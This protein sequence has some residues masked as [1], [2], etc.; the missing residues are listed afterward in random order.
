MYTTSVPPKWL[1][2]GAHLTNNLSKPVQEA[3]GGMPYNL[4][5]VVLNQLITMHMLYWSMWCMSS[6]STGHSYLAFNKKIDTLLNLK[7]HT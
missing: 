7:K 4:A 5:T 1:R 2:K 3:V 6:C